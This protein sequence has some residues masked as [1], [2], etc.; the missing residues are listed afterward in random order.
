M[1]IKKFKICDL[2]KIQYPILLG[3]MLEI[4][5]ASMTAA[6]SQAGGLG[7]LA[8][9]SM[10]KTQLEEQVS[11]IRSKTSLPFGVNISFLLPNA[12]TLVRSCIEQAVPVVITSGGAQPKLLARLK[13]AGITVLQVVANVAQ[14]LRAQTLGLDGVVAKG[15]ESGGVNALNASAT[16]VLI[17]QVV[18]AVSVPVI[19][20]GG[21][22]DGRGLAAATAL[23]A[24]GVLMGTRFLAAKECLVHKDYK[25]AL[26]EAKDTDTVSLAFPQF[27]ARVLKGKAAQNVGRVNSPWELM[28]DP[29]ASYDPENYIYG[30]GQAAGMVGSFNSIQQILEEMMHNGELAS[31]R[32]TD[33]F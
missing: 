23:G 13:N 27:A 4:T 15:M 26:L 21:I 9:A 11:F 7:C 14:A 25:A 30:S 22:A 5:T 2:C 20:A 18:D 1:T 33:F 19:A 3:P 32:L 12:E 28:S 17:P 31:K 24:E 29:K 6:F 8:A 10:D 16:M